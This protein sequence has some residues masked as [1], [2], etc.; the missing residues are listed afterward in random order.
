MERKN[1]IYIIIAAVFFIIFSRSIY[2]SIES[3]K[4]RIVCDEL[5]ERVTDS[6][7]TNRRLAET[8]EKCQSICGEL[9][10]SIDRNINSAR[11]AIELIEQIRTQV[12]ELENCL[13]N[14]DQSEYYQYW[15]SYYGIE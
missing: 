2:N 1:Y 8:V 13:G 6:E 9:G 12:Y 7:N 3:Y 4:F 15:D 14:F 11:E 10:C 5:R